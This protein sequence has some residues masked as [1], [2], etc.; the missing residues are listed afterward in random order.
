MTRQSGWF[1]FISSLI[2]AFLF[3]FTVYFSLNIKE[4]SKDVASRYREI[5]Q[6]RMENTRVKIEAAAVTN[7]LDTLDY[8][9]RRGMKSIPVNKVKVI[10]VKNYDEQ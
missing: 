2:L 8:I 3:F 4:M 1:F 10:E 6:L 9:E 5:E 7:P